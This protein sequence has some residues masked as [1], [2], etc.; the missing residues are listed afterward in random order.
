M[1][2][3]LPDNA[4]MSLI[5]ITFA[6]AILATA[7]SLL[8]GSL[9]SITV[10]GRLNEQKALASTEL[11]ST[12]ED[13]RGMALQDLLEYVP[14]VPAYPGVERAITLECFDGDGSSVDLP[15]ELEKDPI[16]GALAEPLPDLPNPLEVKATLLWKNENGHV[17][18]SFVTT[19]VGR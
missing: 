2:K 14:E 1:N 8:F 7:L 4:G 19:S 16:T 12:L 11:T 3:Q 15:M 10:V 5:E 13:M 17:F 9:I 6:M 18:K